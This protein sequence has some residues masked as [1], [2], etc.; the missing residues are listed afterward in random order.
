M[1]ELREKE[2]RWSWKVLIDNKQRNLSMKVGREE[3]EK[4]G[5]KCRKHKS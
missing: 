2:K 1:E 4:V 5:S 3:Y